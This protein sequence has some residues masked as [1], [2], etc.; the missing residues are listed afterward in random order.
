MKVLGPAIIDW[1]QQRAMEKGAKELLIGRDRVFADIL[2]RARPGD[3]FWVKETYRDFQPGPGCPSGMSAI[4]PGSA[5]GQQLPE[6]IKPWSHKC[7]IKGPL[8]AFGLRRGESRAT[9]RI[10]AIRPSGFQCAVIMSN[11]DEFCRNAA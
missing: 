2:A 8:D 5:M 11:V 10:L 4:V 3:L 7:K 6:H 9:L 1:R